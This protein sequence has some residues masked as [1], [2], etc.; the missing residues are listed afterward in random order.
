[1]LRSR[2]SEF[3]IANPGTVV[4][5]SE[6]QRDVRADPERFSVDVHGGEHGT[7]D[8]CDFDPD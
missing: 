3:L 6:Q 1:M 5:R 7:M 8:A 4:P 2:S